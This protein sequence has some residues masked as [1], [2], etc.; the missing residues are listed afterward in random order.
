MGR[1]PAIARAASRSP[2]ASFALEG[3]LE[4]PALAPAALATSAEW[5]SR[6]VYWAE[7]GGMSETPV[8]RLSGGRLDEKLEGPMLIELPDTVAVL[9]PGQSAEFDELGSLVVD[10]GGRR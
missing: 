7:H 8:L 6:P 5:V 4:P 1:A 3:L 10:L 9:R 2:A